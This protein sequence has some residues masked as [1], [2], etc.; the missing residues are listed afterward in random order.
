[1]GCQK[2]IAEQLVSKQVDYLLA[3]KSNQ[4]KLH[5]A[6]VNVFQNTESITKEEVTKQKTRLEYR[7]YLVLDASV[8]PHRIKEQWPSQ[9][10]V[11]MSDSYRI[12]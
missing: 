10:T 6:L 4:P 7:S 2:V 12:V 5:Q 1:M 9:K 3:V 8:L 11:A